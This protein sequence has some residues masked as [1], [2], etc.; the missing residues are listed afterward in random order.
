MFAL[1][2]FVMNELT[3]PVYVSNEKFEN[4][5]DL[6]PITDENKTHCVYIKDFKRFMRN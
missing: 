1:M 2:Y 4:C 6:L 5:M 3:Y